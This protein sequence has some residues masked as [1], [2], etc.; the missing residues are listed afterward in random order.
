[1]VTSS[2]IYQALKGNRAALKASYHVRIHIAKAKKPHSIGEKLIKPCLKDV[3]FSV[4]DEEAV[5]KVESVPLS[6]NTVA[7]R[8][9]DMAVD[10]QK[11]VVKEILEHNIFSLQLDVS[12]DI[13]GIPQLM[14]C[15]IHQ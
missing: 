4:L 11:S 15:Q 7:A 8:I 12:V 13:A 6:N 5:N 10:I 2:V 14:V 3:C 9:K 1:M